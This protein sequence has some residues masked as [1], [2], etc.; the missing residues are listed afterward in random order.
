MKKGFVLGFIVCLT[1]AFATLAFANTQISAIINEEIRII[2]NGKLQELRD[3]TTNE[4]QYPITYQGRTYLP[5]RT[6][7]KLVGIDVDYEASSKSVLLMTEKSEK[8]IA[9]V[10]NEP[11]TEVKVSN[12]EQFL[13]AIGSNKKIILTSDLYNMVSNKTQNNDEYPSVD[14]WKSEGFEFENISN[15]TIEGEHRAEI[16]IDDIMSNVITF[17][18]CHDIYL[19][20]LK[21]G[22]SNGNSTY[23]CEGAV[24]KLNDCDNVVINNCSLYGCG[25]DGIYAQRST[26]VLVFNTKI[27]DCTY[28]GIW[29]TDNSNAI[30]N[31]TE[32]FDS[33][34]FSGFVRI[35]NSKIECNNCKIENIVTESEFIDSF[36]STYNQNNNI[37]SQAVFNDCIFSNNT[38]EKISSV[39]KD[40]ISFNNCT[41]RNN[42]GVLNEE[43]YDYQSC[44]IY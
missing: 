13:N 2:L 32:F 15:L 38:F 5:L 25:A 30:I 19:N 20:N 6:L 43:Y 1:L 26:N 12:M 4:I 10:G 37:K 35:D 21:V 34:H 29:L 33:V 36:D 17:N 7:A 44:N 16:T 23:E 41:F 9:R 14:M 40:D 39:N 28:S 27:Y 24:I 8:E 11:Q 42:K 31:E 18:N 22:H 3:E